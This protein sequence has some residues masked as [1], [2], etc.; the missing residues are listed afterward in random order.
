MDVAVESR[1]GEYV[2]GYTRG[3]E[4]RE[5]GEEEEEEEIRYEAHGEAS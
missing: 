2:G 3:F 4:V 5:D 1:E